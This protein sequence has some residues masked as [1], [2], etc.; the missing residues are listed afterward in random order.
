MAENTRIRNR[1]GKNGKLYIAQQK[2][3]SESVPEGLVPVGKHFP[4]SETEDAAAE[5]WGHCLRQ[6]ESP[7]ESA[8]YFREHIIL[9]M[10]GCMCDVHKSPAWTAAASMETGEGPR[11]VLLAVDQSSQS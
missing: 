2:E 1:G 8:L 9:E 5:G 7:R 4:H 11:S 10:R 6:S 3:S